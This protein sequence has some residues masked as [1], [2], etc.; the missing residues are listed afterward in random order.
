MRGRGAKKE[1][2]APLSCERN[3]ITNGAA[4][5]A[6]GKSG[7]VILAFLDKQFA[8][9]GPKAWAGAGG[10]NEKKKLR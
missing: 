7:A 6:F 10:K 2:G 1:P 5:Q 8:G 4:F 9:R 3:T